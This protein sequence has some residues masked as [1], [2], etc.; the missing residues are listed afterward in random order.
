MNWRDQATTSPYQTAVSIQQ[1]LSSGNLEEA[2]LGIQELIEALGRSDRRALKSHLQ[3]LMLHIIKWHAQPNRRS[4]SWA[5]SIANAR[6][7]IGDIQAETPSLTDDVI[8]GLWDECFARALRQAEAEMNLESTVKD[9][10]WEQAFQDG[11]D[12]DEENSD[13]PSQ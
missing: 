2:S 8:R 7:E 1:E 10:S 3:Q 13:K 12:L 5:A 11:Y 4:R 9:L 6:D